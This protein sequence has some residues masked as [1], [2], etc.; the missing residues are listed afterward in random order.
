[1]WPF[2]AG[3]SSK[4]AEHLGGGGL[5]QLQTQRLR[6]AILLDQCPQR[7]VENQL[8]VMDNQ[9]ALRQ[10]LHILHIVAREQDGGAL[11]LVILFQEL[12]NALL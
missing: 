12:A 8:P 1:M 2:K 5:L 6:G 7:V 11:A 10:L 3:D 9:H 4:A